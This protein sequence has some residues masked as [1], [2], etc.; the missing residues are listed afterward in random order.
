MPNLEV[1]MPR[2]DAETKARLAEALTE[3]FSLA[4]GFDAKIFGIR[5]FEYGPGEASH[6]GKIWNGQSGEPYIHL[7]LYIPRIRRIHKQNLVASFAAAFAQ[8]SGHADWR[9]VVHI[10][11]HPYD[12]I[13]VEGRLLSDSLPQ[14]KSKPYYFELP[15]D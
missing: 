4:T 14:A 2:T 7:V 12:N 8:A 6:G 5:F 10:C 3:A 1:S 9:P 11:E 13:G 15:D